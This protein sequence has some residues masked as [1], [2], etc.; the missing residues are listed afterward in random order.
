MKFETYIL[1][2]LFVSC[3]L[4]CIVTVSRML[5]VSWPL[6]A[7]ASTVQV[8]SAST[9]TPVACPFL[10]DGVLCVSHD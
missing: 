2:G 7:A 6:P 1:R 3:L 5:F 4:I 9:V 10:H 8:A